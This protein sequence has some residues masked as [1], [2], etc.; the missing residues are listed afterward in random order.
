MNLIEN[1]PV[2]NYRK[3]IE[4][5]IYRKQFLFRFSTSFF[6]SVKRLYSRVSF[7]WKMQCFQ[8]HSHGSTCFFFISEK[9]SSYLVHKV[10]M[11]WFE[12]PSP[13]NFIDKYWFPYHIFFS[14]WSSSGYFTERSSFIFSVVINFEYCETLRSNKEY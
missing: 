10:T 2:V 11:N 9:I 1:G 3:K 12:F 8:I 14:I 6:S 4:I 7:Y 13:M 5:I